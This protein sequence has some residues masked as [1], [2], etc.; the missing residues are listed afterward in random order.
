MDASNQVTVPWRPVGII[1]PSATAVLRPIVPVTLTAPGGVPVET[2]ALLDSG[3]DWTIASFMLLDRLGI[4][5]GAC[6][7]R[8][9]TLN[10]GQSMAYYHPVTVVIGEAFTIRFSALSFRGWDLFGDGEIATMVLG[11][12]DFCRFVKVGLDYGTTT[13]ESREAGV[14]EFSMPDELYITSEG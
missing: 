8:I 3:S 4:D 1:G 10:G 2:R 5:R 6:E 9:G 12:N 11:T 13:M 7:C 14:V